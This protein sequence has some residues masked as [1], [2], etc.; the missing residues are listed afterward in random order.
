M[1]RKRWPW[2]SRY[3]LALVTVALATGIVA[4]VTLIL[5]FPPFVVFVAPVALTWLAA[6]RGP[7]LFALILAA[8]ASDFLFIAPVYQLTLDSGTWRLAFV[9]ALGGAMAR[10]V[11]WWRAKRDARVEL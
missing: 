9:Y 5:S 8:L 10:A 4:L 3:L 7:A 2:W 11:A 6:G 1:L